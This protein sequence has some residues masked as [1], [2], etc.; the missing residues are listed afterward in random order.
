MCTTGR[1]SLENILS[2]SKVSK[3][4]TSDETK[5]PGY[6]SIGLKAAAPTK[7]EPTLAALEAAVK[8]SRKLCA[9]L[10]S[11]LS[12][13]GIPRELRRGSSEQNT[14]SSLN[15]LSLIVNQLRHMEDMLVTLRN[16][17]Q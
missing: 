11:S 5:T 4:S 9:V 12:N 1:G 7:I 6:S 13:P 10:E 3:R 15:D 16:D 8:S 17:T 2:P 14:E